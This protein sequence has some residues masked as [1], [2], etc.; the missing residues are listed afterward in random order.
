MAA[1]VKRRKTDSKGRVVLF[2]YAKR[3]A[4]LHAARPR[5]F[6]LWLRPRLDGF[7]SRLEDAELAND[8]IYALF[9]PSP[10]DQDQSTPA[11]E[12]PGLAPRFGHA[13]AASAM[14]DAA[15]AV[16]ECAHGARVNV[17]PGGD[18]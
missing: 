15:A 18:V 17:H 11:E 7:A 2:R 12:L 8:R 4:G 3:L 10:L 1:A 5:L 9:D 16:L 13:H 14:L 6:D